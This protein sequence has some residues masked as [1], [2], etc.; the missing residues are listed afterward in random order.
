MS[1]KNN[2]YFNFALGILGG[3][4]GGVVA[5]LLLAPKS[6]KETCED[7]MK[8]VEDI[9]EKISPEINEAKKQA[10]DLI[11]TSKVRLEKKYKNFDEALKARKLAKAKDLEC[12]VDNY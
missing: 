10:I 7:I 11:E 1:E 3:V 4:V 6:G 9:G 2:G 12:E 5:G 8:S